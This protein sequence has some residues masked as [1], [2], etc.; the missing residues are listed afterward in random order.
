LETQQLQGFLCTFLP[1]ALL[2]LNVIR[3]L[4]NKGTFISTE[5]ESYFTYS[6]IDYIGTAMF[7]AQNYKQQA[8]IL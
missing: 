6:F 3:G 1:L 4:Y 2:E 5:Q 7:A 8:Y